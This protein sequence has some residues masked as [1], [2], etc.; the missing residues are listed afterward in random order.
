MSAPKVA[1]TCYLDLAKLPWV[2]AIGSSS[3]PG[4]TATNLT[5]TGGGTADLQS[6]ASD[7][8]RLADFH[9]RRQ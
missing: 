2:P 1:S 7:P 9:E 8:W 5:L 4:G 6:G 3:N